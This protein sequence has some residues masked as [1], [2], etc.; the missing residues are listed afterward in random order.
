MKHILT[1]VIIAIMLTS[2]TSAQD[3]KAKSGAGDFG[4]M[5][6][7]GGL[8]NLALNSIGGNSDTNA[9]SGLGGFGA[10]YF[11]SDNLAGRLI[12]GFT[13]TSIENGSS[14][15][16][17]SI[18]PGVLV[19]VA[20]Q[21]PV[22]GYIG[23]QVEFHSTTT[24]LDSANSM[25]LSA[26]GIGAVIG[27]EWFPWSNVS[28]SGEYG[29]SYSGSSSSTETTL[30]N[31]DKKTTDSPAISLVALTGRGKILATIYW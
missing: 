27:A 24:E 11:F 31:G 15:T 23:G 26:F 1:V 18:A 13:S 4:L 9:I 19:N 25:S 2:V 6:D 3:T 16:S 8:A 29:L 5:F 7:L 10:K 21:G 17:F 14:T 22:G 28:L 12:L 30:A 20:S